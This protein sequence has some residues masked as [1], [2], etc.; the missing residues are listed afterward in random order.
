MIIGKTRM[1]EFGQ[2]PFTESV[3]GGYHPQPVEPRAH[4]GRLQRRHGRAVAAGMVPVGIGGDGGGSIRIPAACCGLFG[5]KPERGRVT[6]VA[7]DAPVVGAWGPTG[8]LSRARCSTPRSSTT[9]SAATCRAG[10]LFTA[11]SPRRPSPR[12]R[13]PSR[14]GCGSAGR[15]RS[16]SRAS[17]TPD[18][19]HVQAVRTPR[20]L[21]T[22]LG[23]DVREVDPRYPDPTTAFVPQFLA[24]VRDRG[25]RGRALR[26]VGEANPGGLPPRQLG[27]TA[28]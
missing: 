4:P 28:R 15:P 26:P 1:P 6:T 14:A 7:D 9:P 12:R 5:L 13:A 2:W 10:D 8:P 20:A 21:L 17:A 27:A 24:G 19:S 25:R 16:R 3:A 11:P 23:H 18:P 22:E